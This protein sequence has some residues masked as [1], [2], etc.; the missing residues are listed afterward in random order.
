MAG[1]KQIVGSFNANTAPTVAAL[2]AN[3]Y[4]T[5]TISGVTEV[6]LGHGIWTSLEA[7]ARAGQI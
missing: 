7:A 5:R 1:W 3:G 6:H 2:A 4:E